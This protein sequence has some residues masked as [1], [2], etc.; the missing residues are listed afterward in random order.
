MFGC[1]L[2]DVCGSD[3]DTALGFVGG[4]YFAPDGVR[5]A[6]SSWRIN[7]GLL[8]PRPAP[9]VSVLRVYRQIPGEMVVRVEARWSSRGLAY[10][11]MV[12]ALAV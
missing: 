1:V 2:L 5:L 10:G 6:S 4:L 7:S 9:V 3:I 12:P 11:D 8:Q